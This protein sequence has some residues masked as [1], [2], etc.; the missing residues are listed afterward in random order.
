[1]CEAGRQATVAHVGGVRTLTTSSVHA[2]WRPLSSHGAAAKRSGAAASG[3]QRP[4]RQA[5]GLVSGCELWCPEYRQSTT[6][7]FSD[8]AGALGH[9]QHHNNGSGRGGPPLSEVNSA[10]ECDR[11]RYAMLPEAKGAS[12]GL[13]LSTY[14]LPHHAIDFNLPSDTNEVNCATAGQYRVTL[15]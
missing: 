11:P 9:A 10:L 6:T 12:M 3:T 2:A 1:M 8:T 5:W 15:H 14:S 4:S 7:V 13:D